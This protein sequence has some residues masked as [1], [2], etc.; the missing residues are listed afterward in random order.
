MSRAR[1]RTERGTQSMERSSSMIEPLMRAI[2]YVSNLMSRLGV[3]ALDRSDQPEEPVGDEVALVDVGR[4]AA[5]EPPGDV[6]DERRVREDQPVA[7]G[8]VAGPL[9]L[10]PQSI[11]VVFLLG[12]VAEDRRKSGFREISALFLPEQLERELAHPDSRGTPPRPRS[13]RRRRPGR[14]RRAPAAGSR[15]ARTAKSAPRGLRRTPVQCLLAEGRSSTGRA[16]VSKTGG[17]RFES[18]RPCPSWQ[19]GFPLSVRDAG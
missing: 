9:V 14:P 8:L 6:L 18:W 1:A 5:P 12:H 4:Q 15:A 13:P 10:G 7:G 17:S 19:A 11:G 2:A 16:P 3:E